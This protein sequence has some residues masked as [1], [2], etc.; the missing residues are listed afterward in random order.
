MFCVTIIDVKRCRSDADVVHHGNQASPE[1]PAPTGDDDVAS[2]LEID[3]NR[4]DAPDFR[5]PPPS[6]AAGA[7]EPGTDSAAE[8][9]GSR[10]AVGAPT[11]SWKPPTASQRDRDHTARTVADVNRGDD[12]GR[13]SECR[14]GVLSLETAVDGNDSEVCGD[15]GELRSTGRRHPDCPSSSSFSSSSPYLDAAMSS[16]MRS[17]SEPDVDVQSTSSSIYETYLQSPGQQAIFQLTVTVTENKPYQLG[18]TENG[19]LSAPKNWNRKLEFFLN[20]I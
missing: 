11:S 10:T 20:K 7:A 12:Y 6:I 15:D 4:R 3:A 8:A 17:V 1:M 14:R 5:Y 18:E 16:F 9:V 13:D 2:G 19:K